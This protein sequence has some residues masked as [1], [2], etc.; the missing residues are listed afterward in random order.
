MVK[1]WRGCSKE[2]GSKISFAT[3]LGL[4]TRRINTRQ[5]AGQTDECSKSVCCWIGGIRGAT[6]PNAWS[7]VLQTRNTNPNQ[8]QDS[9]TMNMNSTKQLK[10]ED[11]GSKGYRIAERV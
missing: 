11:C 8:Q 4:A 7:G 2:K 10:T 3:Y 6:Q 5:L 1:A 9:T